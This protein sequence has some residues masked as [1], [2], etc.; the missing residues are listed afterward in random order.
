MATVAGSSRGRGAHRNRRGEGL[1]PR[2]DRLLGAE[3]TEPG[4]QA[5]L[6]VLHERRR[7]LVAVVGLL[8]QD[9]AEDLVPLLRH[10]AVHLQVGRLDRVHVHEL[11]EDGRDVRARE[12]LL[13]R[14]HL[15]AAHPERE[16]VAPPVELV[17]HGLLGRHVGRRAEQGAGLGQVGVGELRDPE[18]G[19]LDPVF[20]VQDQVLR[21]DVAVD[22]ALAVGVVDRRGDL[23]GQADDLLRLEPVAG[24]DEGG[25]GLAVHELHGQVG[26]ALLFADV[27]EGDDVRVGEGAGDPG[28]VVEAVDEGP[29]LRA[30]SRRVEPDGLDG[31]I[32]LDERVIGLVDRAH[33]PESE[34]F[35]HLVAPDRLGLPIGLCRLVVH[36]WPE[37]RARACFRAGPR[38]QTFDFS[39]R[40]KK[41]QRSQ[42]TTFAS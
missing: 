19:D 28:L 33:R 30:L 36:P 18:V 15:E 24:F 40:V 41:C 2:R 27:E 29:V 37:R 8:G 23:A 42:V 20:L 35:E 6:E 34:A 38:R 39:I 12:G 32:P 11:V 7:R 9:A 10:E 26:D 4:A 25:H 1:H 22:D 3:A 17:A 13:A 31:E 16:D 14:E 21:L 5:V